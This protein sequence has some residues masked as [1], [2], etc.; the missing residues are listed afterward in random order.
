MNGILL[1]A[2]CN[3]DGL[4]SDMQR[5]T[6]RAIASGDET[7]VEYANLPAGFGCTH[8][9][10]FPSAGRGGV[11]NG[12]NTEWTDCDGLNDLADRWENYDE[13]WCN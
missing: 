8:Y 11:C 6:Q 4:P 2:D 1:N 3:L 7:A 10:Y 9:V 5:E 12:G 13:R